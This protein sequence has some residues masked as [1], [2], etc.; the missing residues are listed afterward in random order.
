[1]RSTFLAQPITIIPDR[2]RA[3]AISAPIPVISSIGKTKS[4][5][6]KIGEKAC[7][8]KFIK[9]KEIDKSHGE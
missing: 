4:V 2:T 1:M 5:Q 3:A 6:A 8:L 7:K 9:I